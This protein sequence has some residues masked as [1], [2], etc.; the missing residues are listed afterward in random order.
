MGPRP[1]AFAGTLLGLPD[2][3]TFRVPPSIPAMPIASRGMWLVSPVP[4]A[5]ETKWCGVLDLLSAAVK[6]YVFFGWFGG[7]SG[8][9][10]TTIVACVYLYGWG[11]QSWLASSVLCLR[12][13]RMVRAHD[14]RRRQVESTR[15]ETRGVMWGCGAAMFFTPRRP[16]SDPGEA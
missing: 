3:L 13:V 7:G 4:F 12:L 9:L 2:P 6:P 10:A 5:A 16:H 14:W 1:L 11:T 15:L 8:G